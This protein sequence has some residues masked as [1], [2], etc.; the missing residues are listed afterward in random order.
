MECTGPATATDFAWGAGTNI[1]KSTGKNCRSEKAS[2]EGYRK[3]E[4]ANEGDYETYINGFKPM[5][6]Q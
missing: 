4:R 2:R 6:S 1:Q 3:A 5:D